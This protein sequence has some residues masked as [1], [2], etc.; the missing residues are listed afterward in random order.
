METWK[1]STPVIS[2][3][4]D[5]LDPVKTAL[6]L[7]ELSPSDVTRWWEELSTLLKGCFTATRINLEVNKDDP[8]SIKMWSVSSAAD[9]LSNAGMLMMC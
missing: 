4:R 3:S 7:S 8:E 5:S 9:I 1:N 6:L 2:G